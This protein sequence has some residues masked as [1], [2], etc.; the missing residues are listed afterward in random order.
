MVDGRVFDAVAPGAVASTI[1]GIY[2]ALI[3]SQ[4]DRVRAFVSDAA[5][6]DVGTPGDYWRT[7]QAVAAAER[8]AGTNTGRGAQIDASARLTQ[9]ILWDDVEVG[10]GVQLDECIVTDGVQVPPGA[11]HRREILMRGEDGTTRV[12]PL[13]L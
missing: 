12:S 10:A 9:S 11:T 5:F 6:S 13:I 2:D 7:S 1:G 8:N 3:L 4:P